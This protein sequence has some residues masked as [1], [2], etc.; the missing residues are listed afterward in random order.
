MGV[1]SC[2]WHSAARLRGTASG[3]RASG[4]SSSSGTV[5]GDP[6]PQCR[7]PHTPHFGARWLEK[8]RTQSY[9]APSGCQ[10]LLGPSFSSRPRIPRTT[11]GTKGPRGENS[12]LVF[13]TSELLAM[14]RF[15]P[16]TVGFPQSTSP[17]REEGEWGPLPFFQKRKPRKEQAQ[18]T[19]SLQ[20]AGSVALTSR[21][22]EGHLAGLGGRA[23]CGLHSCLLSRRRAGRGAQAVSLL[24]NRLSC[25][26]TRLLQSPTRLCKHAHQGCRPRRGSGTPPPLA[27]CS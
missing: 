8:E 4:S 23:S 16:W 2:A 26:S 20:S 1:E 11:P 13:L 7:R 6:C 12:F 24:T 22:G 5:E 9:W 25:C 18:T 19:A 21:A 27:S 15:C 17:P 10:H 14:L 3:V